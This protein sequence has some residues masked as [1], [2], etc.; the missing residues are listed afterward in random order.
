MPKTKNELE[1]MRDLRQA[2]REELSQ[3]LHRYCPEL[4]PGRIQRIIDHV[5]S[6]SFA[7]MRYGEVPDGKGGR[8]L[9]SAATRRGA[10]QSALL[11][12]P[13]LRVLAH[14]A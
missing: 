5:G 9:S 10:D 14:G 7:A 2:R 6:I 4:E 11:S 12:L 13:R 3:Y 8:A 1:R